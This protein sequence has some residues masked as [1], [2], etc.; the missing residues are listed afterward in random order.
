MT[1]RTKTNEN[2]N[3][4]HDNGLC[5]S[6]PSGDPFA[7]SISLLIFLLS[8]WKSLA[9]KTLT[10]PR[11]RPLRSFYLVNSQ[12]SSNDE[13]LSPTQKVIRWFLDEMRTSPLVEEKHAEHCQ[14]FGVTHLFKGT[15]LVNLPDKYKLQFV[16][17]WAGKTLATV[18]A[19]EQVHLGDWKIE[20]II[21]AAGKYDEEEVLQEM[22]DQ[23]NGSEVLMYSFEDCPWCIAAK[24]LLEEEYH[25]ISLEVIELE[26]LGPKGKAIRAELAKRTKRT[27]LPA[28]FVQGKPIG[29]FTDGIPCGPGLEPLH[30]SGDLIAM[31]KQ[32]I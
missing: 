12:D 11:A 7:M 32:T 10:T 19:E 13:T 31:L 27:S 5:H 4:P 23:I 18:M 9:F 3:K 24:A 21:E 15:P 16:D 6:S 1:H 17:S 2:E 30:K 14:S 26:S 22:N 28:I 25:G 8:L 29:G 20:K